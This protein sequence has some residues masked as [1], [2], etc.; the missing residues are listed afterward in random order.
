M[1]PEEVI[2]L[3]KETPDYPYESIGFNTDSTDK[4][5]LRFLKNQANMVKCLSNH[6]MF[7]LLKPCFVVCCVTFLV[8]F[9]EQQLWVVLG[10]DMLQ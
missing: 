10:H 9:Q 3:L 1:A 6:H 4:D 5:L 2:E 8:V 7:K